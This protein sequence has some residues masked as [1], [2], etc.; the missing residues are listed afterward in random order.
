MISSNKKDV[1]HK[2]FI[3]HLCDRPFSRKHDL[4]RHV[5]V[6]T[7]AKPYQCPCCQKSFGRTDA[8]KRH[9]RLEDACR[10]SPEVQAMKGA[11]QRRFKNL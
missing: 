3:C 2:P 9:L 7:G 5:R 8:L 6:H 11:G 1:S 10:L 4:H